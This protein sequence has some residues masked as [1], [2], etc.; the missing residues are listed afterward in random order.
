M[1]ERT[2]YSVRARGVSEAQINIS[3]S[4][5]TFTS[6]QSVPRETISELGTI[7]GFGGTW[8]GPFLTLHHFPTEVRITSSKF[9]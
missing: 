6:S 7:V 8:W 3:A 1:D 9:I 4:V 2:F 5:P